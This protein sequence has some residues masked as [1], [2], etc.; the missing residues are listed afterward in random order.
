MEEREQIKLPERS[1][2]GTALRTQTPHF[3]TTSC[4]VWKSSVQTQQPTFTALLQNNTKPATPLQ[5]QP[6]QNRNPPPAQ[7]ENDIRAPNP[8]RNRPRTPRNGTLAAAHHHER[9]HPRHVSSYARRCHT[10]ARPAMLHFRSSPMPW[11]GRSQCVHPNRHHPLRV[12][13]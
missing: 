5:Y 6:A 11:S 2:L 1:A 8:P 7:D 12:S 10:R 4:A 3:H 13:I 9:H